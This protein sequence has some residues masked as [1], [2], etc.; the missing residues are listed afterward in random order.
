MT[1]I[2]SIDLAALTAVP[3]VS[4]PQS[5][6][7]VYDVARFQEAYANAAPAQV[8]APPAIEPIS[9]GFQAVL[10]NFESLNGR[11]GNINEITANLEAGAEPTPGEMMQMTVKCHEFLFHAEMTSNVANRTSDGVQQLFRQQS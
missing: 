5:Q 3:Q 10:Q 8:S 2:Q 4:G 1:P 6:A 11:V 7:A 9:P